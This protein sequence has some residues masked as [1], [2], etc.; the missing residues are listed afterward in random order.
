MKGHTNFRSIQLQ[1][2]YGLSDQAVIS[3]AET[4]FTT[5]AAIQ[6]MPKGD[7]DSAH[8]KSI[9]EHI[10]GDMYPWAGSFRTAKLTIGD[11]YAETTTPPA[12]LEMEVERVLTSMKAEPAESMNS[13]EF[14][15]KMA[16]YYTKLYALSPFPDGNAR[17]ARF[18]VDAFAEKHQMQ[19]SWDSVPAEAFHSAVKQSL[20]GNQH[21]IKQVFRMMT[22]HQDLY[23]LHSVDAIQTT[24]AKIVQKAGLR[25]GYIPSQSITSQNDLGQLAGFVK[26][27]LAEDLK[28]YAS[29]GHTMRDWDKTSIQHEMTGK[30]DRSMTGPQALSQALDSMN[31][32]PPK[33]RGPG[34]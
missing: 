29:G 20:A 27:R 15:D 5:M 23:A 13:I 16:G 10:L 28:N 19:V 30:V 22:D 18:M 34:M 2:N 17:A 3:E 21:G 1:N 32:P 14:A 11:G 4:L 12:L 6:G 31:A 8:L 24:M 25:E 33:V 26:A 7:F 9:H